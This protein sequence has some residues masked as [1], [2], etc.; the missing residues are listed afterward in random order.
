MPITWGVKCLAKTASAADYKGYD[1][2]VSFRQNKKAESSMEVKAMTITS[3][4]TERRTALENTGGDG[5]T[6][7]HA[8]RR[9]RAVGYVRLGFA[10]MDKKDTSPEGQ[11]ARIAAC[12]DANGW[13]LLHVYEDIGWSGEDLDRPSLPALLSGLGFEI[14]VVDRTDRLTTKKKDLDFLLALM[15]KHGI[16]CVPATW[17]WE[18]MAQYM[19]WWYRRRA[20]PV[21]ALLDTALASSEAGQPQATMTGSL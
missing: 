8:P 1:C 15:E 3:F 19:R 11:K 13:H 2:R 20:N 17:S 14:L 6:R 18:P 16:T 5:E 12:A 9:M 10:E 21:Y 7:L 4:E